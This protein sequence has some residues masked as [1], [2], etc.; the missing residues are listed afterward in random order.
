[1]TKALFRK[2]CY[3]PVQCDYLHQ[4]EVNHVEIVLQNMLYTPYIALCPTDY[5]NYSTQ[6]IFQI[7]AVDT[8]ASVSFMKEKGTIFDGRRRYR[9]K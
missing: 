6:A 8:S 7:I 1:M 2:I 9:W 4:P 5:S 3:K